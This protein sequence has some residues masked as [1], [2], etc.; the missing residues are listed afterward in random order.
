MAIERI[1]EERASLL[2]FRIDGRIERDDIEAMAREVLAAFEERGEVDMLILLEDWDGIS[3]G[4]ILSRER[5]EAQVSAVRHVRKYAVV[6]PPDWAAALINGFDRILPV[7]A[8]TFEAGDEAAARAWLEE[9]AE[10]LDR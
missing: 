5:V 8:R 7:D 10:T 6:G 4:A 2:A 9:G 1:E 3:A